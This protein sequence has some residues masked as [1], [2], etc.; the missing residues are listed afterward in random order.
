[1]LIIAVLLLTAAACGVVLHLVRL[2]IRKVGTRLDRLLERL[3]D[4]IDRI[5]ERI[6]RIGEH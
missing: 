3:G 5:S 1:M 2:E 6:D 4:R